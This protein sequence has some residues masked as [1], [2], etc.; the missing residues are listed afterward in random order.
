MGY[1]LLMLFGGI[2][3]IT[4]QMI[5]KNIRIDRTNKPLGHNPLPKLAGAR[6]AVPNRHRIGAGRGRVRPGCGWLQIQP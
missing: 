4:Y 1:N 2:V 5:Y 6:E 3:N